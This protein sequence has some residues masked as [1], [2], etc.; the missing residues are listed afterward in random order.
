MWPPEPA[1]RIWERLSRMG[2]TWVVGGA[3]REYLLG[4]HQEG[5]AGGADLDL[6]TAI[7]PDQVFRHLSRMGLKPGRSGMVWGRVPVAGES[8][9]IDITTFRED[10]GVFDHRHPPQVRFT[11]HG[12][13]DLRR[14][15][16]TVNAMALTREG[17]LVDV[18]AGAAHLLDRRLA[19]VG[20]PTARLQEDAV[21]IW[22]AV[23]FLAYGDRA[24]TWDRALAMA[25]AE[26]AGLAQLVPWERIGQEFL[27][28]LTHEHPEWALMA[29]YQLGLLPPWTAA[30]PSLQSLSPGARLAILEWT[31]RDGNLGVR[32]GLPR[33]IK[34]EA[35]VLRDTW[36]GRAP[37]LS[38][39]AVAK[40]VAQRLHM[41]WDEPW[42]LSGSDL[43]RH[44]GLEPGPRLGKLL[45][46][47]RTWAHGHPERREP[48][49][50]DRY[51]KAWLE[52]S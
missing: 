3:V 46:E 12:L 17:R 36:T 43:I 8:G 6:A 10:A 32:Y 24:W 38:S 19:T 34:R 31:W 2:T 48:A 26:R 33:A 15:D 45:T 42:F 1:R 11:R 50:V 40:D 9:H 4:R 20:D 39:V 51:V 37:D 7:R 27:A 41:A 28:I 35:R 30:S 52:K 5:R 25:L 18:T 14:R 29:A 49:Q 44:Y 16:F 13:G 21:R 23:R 47:I 22:R